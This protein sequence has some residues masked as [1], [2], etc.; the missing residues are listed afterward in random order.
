LCGR[1][2]WKL[3]FEATG[4]TQVEV[5]TSMAKQSTVSG[6]PNQSVLE[7]ETSMGNGALPK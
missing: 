5:L 2:V 7:E 3:L 6:I 1:Q 4:D